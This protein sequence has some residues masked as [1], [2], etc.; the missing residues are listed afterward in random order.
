[1]YNNKN[2]IEN[3]KGILSLIPN[4]IISQKGAEKKEQVNQIIQALDKLKYQNSPQK[5][6]TQ[7]GKT[8]EQSTSNISN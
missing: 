8:Y 5:N 6:I 7:K 1:M 3:L 2:M 4:D